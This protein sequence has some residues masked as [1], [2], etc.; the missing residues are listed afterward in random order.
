MLARLTISS[1]S[2]VSA[3]VQEVSPVTVTPDAPL[4]CS[5]DFRPLPSNPAPGFSSGASAFARAIEIQGSCSIQRAQPFA[6]WLGRLVRLLLT[7]ADH[8]GILLP[9]YPAPVLVECWTADL[10]G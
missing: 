3:S 9:D 5:R 2:R 7:S 4:S 10:P 6:R 8:E 1:I